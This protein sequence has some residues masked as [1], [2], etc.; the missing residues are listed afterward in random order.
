MT[1]GPSDGL[2]VGRSEGASE[3]NRVGTVVGTALGLVDGST[4]GT[5][6]STSQRIRGRQDLSSL[7]IPTDDTDSREREGNIHYA[8]LH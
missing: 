6:R 2:S 7:A 1:V 4:D 8:N 3:G 5:W